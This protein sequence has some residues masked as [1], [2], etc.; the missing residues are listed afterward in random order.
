VSF[1]HAA[2]AQ[3]SAIL[4]PTK[5]PA[6]QAPHHPLVKGALAGIPFV[7]AVVCTGVSLASCEDKAQAVEM[8]II[9]HLIG[10]GVPTVIEA[11][12]DHT[13]RL[14][15]AASHGASLLCHALSLTCTT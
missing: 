14:G 5:F 13:V 10:S 4:N 2:E 6:L 8:F 9:G 3:H 11:V 7:C 12:L 1:E 15:P